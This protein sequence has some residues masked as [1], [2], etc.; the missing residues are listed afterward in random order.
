MDSMMEIEYFDERGKPLEVIEVEEEKKK[1]Y[2]IPKHL[3]EQVWARYIGDD[4]NESHCMSCRKQKV[5]KKTFVCG[6]VICYKN[7]GKITIENLRPIC[8]ACSLSIKNKDLMDFMRER[9]YF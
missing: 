4:K 8:H 9:G 5:N 1:N 7:G 6:R 3:K 2:Y